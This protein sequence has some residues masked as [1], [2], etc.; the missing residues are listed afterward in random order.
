MVGHI[1]LWLL[2]RLH[3]RRKEALFARMNTKQNQSYSPN[4]RADCCYRSGKKTSK[5]QP[6]HWHFSMTAP[7]GKTVK[8]SG[9]CGQ[10]RLSAHWLLG[11][12]VSPTV[13]R[14][15]PI[16]QPFYT[17]NKGTKFDIV[18]VSLDD[19]KDRW[20]RGIAKHKLTW[21]HLSDLQKW[22]QWGCK[23]VCRKCHSG[24]CA[25]W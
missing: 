5:G 16:W 3:S 11:F 25:H 9:L 12:V 23:V 17:R 14:H 6:V 2:L 18:G 21:H 10:D 8:L 7:D 24:N 15:S 20:I 13:W 19:D 22:S 1:Y 4:C